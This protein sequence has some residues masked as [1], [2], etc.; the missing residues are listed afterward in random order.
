M[1]PKFLHKLKLTNEEG[2]LRSPNMGA[3]KNALRPSQI[4]ATVNTA[5]VAIRSGSWKTTY[6]EWPQRRKTVVKI[7]LQALAGLMLFFVFLIATFPSEKAA[8][9]ALLVGEQ[10]ARVGLTAEEYDGYWL[11]GFR[12]KGLKVFADTGKTEPPIVE[13]DDIKVRLAL[14]PLFL[15]SMTISAGGELYG[16]TF[17]VKYS[18]RGI[19]LDISGHLEDVDISLFGMLKERYG[20]GLLGKMDLDLDYFAA[21]LGKHKGNGSLKL[22]IKGF[23]FEG[24][25][26]GIMK[27]EPILDET[28]KGDIKISEGVATIKSFK[29]TGNALAAEIDGRA[30]IDEQFTRTKLNL[31]IHF[32]PADD[33]EADL[34]FIFEQMRLKKSRKGDYVYKFNKSL[35]QIF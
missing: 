8:E 30:V 22:K 10:T 17:D 13:I 4:A 27:V 18:S 20:A 2:K 16:G 19:V 34:G 25:D 15:G 31:N 33:R 21:E 5:V 7:M 24:L 32:K 26:L 11:S 28:I 35:R 23:G 9:Y 1:A 14:L 3:V 12:F 6:D 29:L